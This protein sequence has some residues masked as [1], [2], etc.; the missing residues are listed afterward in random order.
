MEFH[1]CRISY[2]KYDDFVE[3][4]SKNFEIYNKDYFLN[5]CNEMIE[6][7]IVDGKA[8][9][10]DIDLDDFLH[11]HDVITSLNKTNPMQAIDLK[12]S[13]LLFKSLTLS[14]HI[15]NFLLYER[16]VWTYLNCF[17]FFEIVKKRYF[18]S[19]DELKDED[20]V[21]RYFFCKGGNGL[22][23]RGLIWLWALSDFT[24]DKQY[25]FSLTDTAMRF[26]D[27]VKAFKERRIGSNTKVLKAFIRAIQIKNYDSRIKGTRFR[28]ILITHLRNLASMQIYESIASVEELAKVFAKDIE[29]FISNYM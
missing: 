29:E 16:E 15:P 28:S 17:V 13:E 10:F 14:A 4:F 1:L 9:T 20:R 27:P 12:F 24:Y 23:R 25:A 3:R 7:V 11:Q 18:N 26:I 6:D 5:N 8:L 22:D 2:S 21:K 19:N